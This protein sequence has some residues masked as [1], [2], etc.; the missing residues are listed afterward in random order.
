MSAVLERGAASTVTLSPTTSLPQVNLLPPGVRAKAALSRLKRVLVLVLV[1]V[2]ALLALGYAL[3]Q[4]R[5]SAAQSE[6]SDAQAETA[7]L[8]Q[9]QSQYSEAP[10]VLGEVNRLQ[11]A[12]TQGFS[13]EVLWTPYLG[14]IA[15]VMPPG[16]VL[17]SIQMTGATPMQAP[18]GPADVLQGPSVGQ[19]AFTGRSATLIDT[20]GWID[21][22]NS[23]PG[24]ADAWVSNATV[25]ADDDGVPYYEIT[26][27]VQVTDLAYSGRFAGEGK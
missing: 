12:R 11:Q 8:T 7:R 26:S 27:T 6:L 14:A 4:M 25:A 19:L 1:G 17:T 2:A 22:L 24:F 21:A 5:L 16:V 18:P 10:R 9:Q 3:A 23:V 20:A 13:T 15:A